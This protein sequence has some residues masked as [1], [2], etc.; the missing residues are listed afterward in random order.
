MTNA[1]IMRMRF[2]HY[3]ELL[4]VFALNSKSP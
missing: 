1:L 4:K 2:Y 3:K